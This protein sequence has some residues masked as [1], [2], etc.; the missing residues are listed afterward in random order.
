MSC[1]LEEDWLK[2]NDIMSKSTLVGAI[3]TLEQVDIGV[4]PELLVD[5]RR[6]E[7]IGNVQGITAVLVRLVHAIHL[8][9]VVGVAESVL[10]LF[11]ETI[12]LVQVFEVFAA[13]SDV[14]FGVLVHSLAVH[15]VVVGV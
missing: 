5:G 12:H 1:T 2:S 10:S 13:L 9:A 4:C 6:Q 11:G 14:G 7:R 8:F 15:A 3:V